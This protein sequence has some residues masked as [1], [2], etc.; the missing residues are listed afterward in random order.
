MWAW[1]LSELQR[2]TK[3]LQVNRT[4]T[5]VDE[6]DIVAEV[7]LYLCQ[8][9]E[10]AQDIYKNKKIM[11]LYQLARAEIYNQRAKQFFKNK[12][13]LSL[14]QKIKDVCDKYKI[15][16]RPENAYKIS[17]LLEESSANFNI[18]GIIS[19]LSQDNPLNNGYLSKFQSYE[20]SLECLHNQSRK[21]YDEN[22]TGESSHLRKHKKWKVI[23]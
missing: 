14:W 3:S 16:M 11:L 6:D 13:E 19:L 23:Q 20:E 9:Q 1:I 8:N 7:L 21:E 17:A 15:E 2:I 18:S 4:I 5:A 12:M 10:L 22:E